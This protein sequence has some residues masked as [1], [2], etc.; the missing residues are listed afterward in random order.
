MVFTLATMPALDRDSPVPLYRQLA[1]ELRRRI[2][3]EDLTRLPSYLTLTQEYEVSRPVA[4]GAV[5]LLVAEGLVE[6]S[7]GRGAFVRR[8]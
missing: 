1:D 4:E 2:A 3:R 6:I 7:P 5:K 8:Q